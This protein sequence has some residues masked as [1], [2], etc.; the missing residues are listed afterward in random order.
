ML[1]LKS[2]WNEVK[3]ARNKA[4]ET[5]LEVS[6]ILISNFNTIDKDSSIYDSIKFGYDLRLGKLVECRICASRLISPKKINMMI[7]EMNNIR[8]SWF[9]K[10]AYYSI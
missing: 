5:Y 9:H 2:F 8:D 1:I 3:T 7:D 6:D 4:E 10:L